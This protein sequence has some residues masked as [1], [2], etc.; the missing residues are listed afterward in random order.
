MWRSLARTWQTLL[1]PLLLRHPAPQAPQP[2]QRMPRIPP[3]LRLVLPV[4]PPVPPLLLRALPVRLR[5]L[6]PMLRTPLRRRPAPLL[7]LLGLPL[8]RPLARPMR[9]PAPLR[10]LRRT[11]A[12]T[13]VT[14]APRRPIP[15][16][17]TMVRR[18]SPEHCTGI[19]RVTCCVST[20]ALPGWMP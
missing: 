14:W 6:P 7:L 12:S 3:L 8:R 13:T 17:T 16:W 9:H 1:H 4:L 2:R 19:P 15:P 18:Y 5:P 10:R 11:T 20:T